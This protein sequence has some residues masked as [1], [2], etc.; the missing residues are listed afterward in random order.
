MHPNTQYRISKQPVCP[1]SKFSTFRFNHEVVPPIKNIIGLRGVVGISAVT[2]GRIST[3]PVFFLV[4]QQISEVKLVI[5][6]WVQV[7]VSPEGYRHPLC[8]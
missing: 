6:F 3:E 8:F 7:E 1:F 4:I 2:R 5:R